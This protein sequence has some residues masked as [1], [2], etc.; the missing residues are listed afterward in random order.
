MSKKLFWLLSVLL[1]AALLL[2]ACSPA[3]EPAAVTDAPPATAVPAQPTTA[4]T[5]PPA[6]TATTQPEPPALPAGAGLEGVTWTLATYLDAAG[7]SQTVLANTQVTAVFADAKVSG[8]AGC[9]NYFASY[10]LDGD[11]LS[12]APAGSTM[13]FCAVPAGVMDQESAYL[14]ALES[15]ATYSIE[16]GQLVLS[17]ATGKTILSYTQAAETP[18][19]DAAAPFVGTTWEVVSYSDAATTVATP[20]N[21]TKLTALFGVDSQVTGS[22]G[23]NNFSGGYQIDGNQIK[24]GQ[25][26]ATMMA[27]PEPPGAMNQEATYL[28]SLQQAVRFQVTGS[29]LELFNFL[30]QLVVV[31]KVEG[32]ALPTPAV[33]AAAAAGTGL[34]DE[35]LL[36]ATYKNEFVTA[37]T[38]TLVDGKYTEQAVPGSAIST[39]VSLV[40]PIAYGELADGQPA[41]AVV[42]VT[43]SGGSGTFY[44]LHLMQDLNGQ[45]IN[46]ATTFLGDRIQLNSVAFQ[47]GQIVV[48]MVTQGPGDAMCCPTQAV[49]KTFAYQDNSLVEISS[50]ES[51]PA[52]G[53][54][55]ALTG[56][57]WKWVEFQDSAGKIV[58]SG[59]PTKYTLEF[60]SG[61]KVAVKADCNTGTGVYQVN[62]S[63]LTIT[64]QTL[65]LDACQPGSLS[66]QFV[67]YLG[68]VVSYVFRDDNLYLALKFDSGIMEFQ[69]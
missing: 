69:P 44:T 16:A 42:L 67:Q 51:G 27:C 34:T 48:D 20:I 14:K 55:G 12:I 3:A 47:D 46:V 13:M 9:N 45:P 17:D 10:K 28:A 1:A 25:L 40:E 39:T 58:S 60:L 29:K 19:A 31:Y 52:E 32:T 59:D 8:T 23:C 36:N 56:S 37:G 4:P 66:S 24:I 50:V 49:T 22:G 21:G 38:V 33:P 11:K 54:T 53:S 18:A 30:D 35:A 43:S 57:L 68:N 65:T 7:V 62:G 2:S 64:I 41:A 26:A 5:Q 15:V 63:M 61:G 6:P